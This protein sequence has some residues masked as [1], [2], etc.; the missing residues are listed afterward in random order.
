MEHIHKCN[1]TDSMFKFCID[2]KEYYI[3]VNPDRSSKLT[4]IPYFTF[5]QQHCKSKFNRLAYANDKNGYDTI[6]K[7]IHKLEDN[8]VFI[9]K[10]NRIYDMH[11]ERLYDIKTNMILKIN[12][13]F[14]MFTYYNFTIS[15]NGNTIHF[16]ETINGKCFGGL[17]NIAYG[18]NTLLILMQDE[19]FA[20]KLNNIHNI[21]FKKR[22]ILVAYKLQTNHNIIKLII[23]KVIFR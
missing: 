14:Y 10:N 2:C 6:Y 21:K 11:T 7:Y 9:Y 23:D 22:F 5:D 19:L 12:S 1:Y 17:D 3:D 8:G 18:N 20:Y 13:P 4:S 15:L 16:N